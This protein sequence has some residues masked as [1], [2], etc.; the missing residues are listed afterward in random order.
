MPKLR[1]G[2]EGKV[3]GLALPWDE[4]YDSIEA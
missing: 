2:T 3:V 1:Y 4:V